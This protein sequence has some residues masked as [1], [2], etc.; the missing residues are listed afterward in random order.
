VSDD[1]GVPDR[2]DAIGDFYGKKVQKGTDP[3][4]HALRTWDHNEYHP[5]QSRDPELYGLICN[6]V[7]ADMDILI[8]EG[9]VKLGRNHRHIVLT[10]NGDDEDLFDLVL[11]GAALI[12]DEG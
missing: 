12:S 1:P 11:E 9:S 8:G 2:F 5:L 10:W 4:Q 7:G 6:Q 3:L